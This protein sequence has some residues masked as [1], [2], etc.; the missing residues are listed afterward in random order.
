LLFGC[1]KL[2]DIERMMSIASVFKKTANGQSNLVGELLL[3]FGELLLKFGL[4]FFIF[5]PDQC[6]QVKTILQ[7]L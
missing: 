5:S 2:N 3:F 1:F 7:L 4:G 6:T